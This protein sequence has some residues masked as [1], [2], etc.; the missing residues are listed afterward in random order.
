MEHHVSKLC[1]RAVFVL[2]PPG[3]SIQKL[4]DLIPS[5]LEWKLVDRD[6]LPSWIHADGK[7]VLLGDSCHPMLVCG[8]PTH[9]YCAL[10]NIPLAL[11]RARISH[12]GKHEISQTMQVLTP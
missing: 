11:P 1:C 2:M 12:G 3:D 4:I 5:P 6:P 8:F 10:S 9:A 7:L